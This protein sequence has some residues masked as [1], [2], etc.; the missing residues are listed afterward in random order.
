MK[1]RIR[2]L[3]R[4]THENVISVIRIPNNRL[5]ATIVALLDFFYAVGVSKHDGYHF[6]WMKLR[7]FVCP[8]PHVH[9]GDLTFWA[10]L[11]LRQARETTSTLHKCVC[12]CCRLLCSSFPPAPP[13]EQWNF[14]HSPFYLV[15]A[16]C[17]YRI[18]CMCAK[19]CR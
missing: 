7:V 14:F 5:L 1:Q 6:K 13:T 12:I 3:F 16:F 9:T 10:S 8:E 17:C 11:F 19:F 2:L 18:I 15:I 4:R